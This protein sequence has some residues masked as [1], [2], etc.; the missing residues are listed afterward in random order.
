MRIISN[1]KTLAYKL[2]GVKSVKRLGSRLYLP[3][4][5]LSEMNSEGGSLEHTSTFE[6]QVSKL[7]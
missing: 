4:E 5:A 7:V 6:T 3:D 2:R 1:Q